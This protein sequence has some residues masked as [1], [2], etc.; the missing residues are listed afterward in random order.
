MTRTNQETHEALGSLSSLDALAD[1]FAPEGST[2]IDPLFGA[3]YGRDAIRAW[4]VPVMAMI[5]NVAFVPT[6]PAAFVD[7]GDGRGTSVDEWIMEATMDD[8]RVVQMAR[9]CS[10][11]RYRDGWIVYN[12]DH[13]DTWSSRMGAVEEG[14]ADGALTTEMLAG[15]GGVMAFADQVAR[16]REIFG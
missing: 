15:F 5:P 1:L 13:Y 10:V 2:Y 9:G 4:I 11:R 7:H 12:A 3:F 14:G 8:G 6:A 16:E